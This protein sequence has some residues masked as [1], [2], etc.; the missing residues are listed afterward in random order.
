[1]GSSIGSAIICVNFES[2]KLSPAEKKSSKSDHIVCESTWNLSWF[3]NLILIY[4]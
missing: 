3:V 2:D 4:N 1:M